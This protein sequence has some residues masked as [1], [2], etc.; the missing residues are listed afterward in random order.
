MKNGHIL[1]TPHLT[2][3]ILTNKRQNTSPDL[4]VSVNLIWCIQFDKLYIHISIWQCFLTLALYHEYVGFLSRLNF[5]L[6]FINARIDSRASME[7][8]N[9]KVNVL[10]IFGGKA[11]RL[12]SWSAYKNW[13]KRP[14]PVKKCGRHILTVYLLNDSVVK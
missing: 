2:T 10:E 13:Q 6:S 3:R 9:F 1:Y 7:I 12:Y 14:D 8:S 11:I 5:P 4:A